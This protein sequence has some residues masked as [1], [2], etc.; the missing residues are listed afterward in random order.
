MPASY[1]PDDYW[2]QAVNLFTG[3]PMPDRA[4]LF[5]KISSTEEIPLF[6]M[7]VK[8]TTTRSLTP[9]DFSAIS[10][11]GKSGGEDYDLAFYVSGGNGANSSSSHGLKLYKVRIVFIGVPVDDKGRARLLDDGE[12]MAGGPFKGSVTG[13]DWDSGAMSQYISGS[14]VAIDKLVNDHTTRGLSYSGGSVVDS[15][16]VDLNSFERTARAFDRASR[17]F[18]DHGKTVAAWEKQLGD[19]QAAWKGKA[20]GVFWHLIHQINKN[21]ESYVEQ[22]GGAE[23]HPNNSTVGGYSPASRY[24]DS[25]ALA[26]RNLYDQVVNLQSAWTAWAGNYGLHD[27]HRW[28]LMVL[29]DL[30]AWLLNNNVMQVDTNYN[31]YAT[32]MQDHPIYGDLTRVE[33]WKKVGEEAVRL[34]NKHVDEVLTPVATQA[35]S[36]LKGNWID[37]GSNFDE[38]LKTK[39]TSSLSVSY[40]Q[41]QNE[42]DQ[43]KANENQDNLNAS[44]GGIG[45][46]LNNSLGNL[47]DGLNEGLGGIGDGLNNS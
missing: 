41:E 8:S 38:P 6:R 20:A 7:D 35:I 11:W 1:G 37:V 39:D 10:G 9:D 18:V 36:T 22:L 45:D 13:T 44:L 31:T 15:D 34:W 40:T 27:P 12:T 4:H 46:N 3:Y 43:N 33:N 17:F 14:K 23:Y 24:A 2:G 25:L 16:A 29:D 19:E 42:I 21:Y 5:E 32:F 47:G 28:L 30:S 26:Q